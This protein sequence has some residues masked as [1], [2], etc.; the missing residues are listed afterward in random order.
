MNN[1]KT[2]IIL[3]IGQFISLMGTHMSGFAIGLHLYQQTNSIMIYSLLVML[4]IMPEIVIAPIAGVLIDRW[5]RKYAMLLGHAGAGVGSVVIMVLLY[6]G[7][8][9]L[10]YLIPLITISSIFNGFVFPAFTAA[11][12]QLLPKEEL[13]KAGGLTQAGFGLVMIASPAVAGTLFANYGLTPIFAIDALTFTLAILILLCIKIPAVNQSEMTNAEQR[14]GI[15]EELKEGFQFI[16]QHNHLIGI[17]VLMSLVNINM[18]MLNVLITPLVLSVSDSTT[19]GVI[20]S[21]SGVGVLV[22]SVLLILFNKVNRHEMKIVLF[23]FLQGII[24]VAAV[25]KLS[26][27]TLG[28]ASFLFMACAGLVNGLNQ[29]LWQI[30]VP[31]EIQGRIFSFLT[32]VSGGTF[33]LGYM[34]SGPL[35]ELMKPLT[36]SGFPIVDQ[37]LQQITEGLNKEI[38]ILLFITG[39]LTIFTAI[40]IRFFLKT[41]RSFS[42]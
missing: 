37:I 23:V 41:K 11:T 20:L 13:T 17:L 6:M 3:L 42:T 35:I 29:A 5:N 36:Q 38:T 19:V 9:N 10:Y 32:T 28:I 14:P 1:N 40:I 18:G 26:V 21:V 7:S 4:T 31:E 33:L 2:F 34:V 39:I 15:L 8:T 27:V 25:F 16:R 12:S 24:L 22:G 30:T